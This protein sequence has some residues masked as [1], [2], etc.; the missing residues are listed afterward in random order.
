MDTMELSIFDNEY[1]KIPDNKAKLISKV[2]DKTVT[3]LCTFPDIFNYT[4]TLKCSIN[5]FNGTDPFTQGI[6]S[7]TT[8]DKLNI[9]YSYLEIDNILKANE[10]LNLPITQESEKTERICSE[11]NR[12]KENNIS[13]IIV[14]AAIG[15]TLLSILF[16]VLRFCI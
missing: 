12:A 4:L 10:K 16:T 11:E 5:D 7:T 6:E 2:G 1:N 3:S 13:P 15:A 14:G 8:E 9:V